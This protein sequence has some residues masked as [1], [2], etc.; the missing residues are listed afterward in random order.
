VE[1][2]EGPKLKTEFA[3]SAREQQGKDPSK[4]DQADA[5]EL[6]EFSLFYQREHAV[7]YLQRKMGYHYFVFKRLIIEVQQRMP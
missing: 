7:A 4:S 6:Q 3:T 5:Q 1:S 2:E